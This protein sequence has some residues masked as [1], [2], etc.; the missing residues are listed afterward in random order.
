MKFLQLTSDMPNCHKLKETIWWNLPNLEFLSNGR[1]ALSH[2]VIDFVNKPAIMNPL[3]I[4]TNLID[5]DI[6][7]P[8]GLIICLPARTKDLVH[9]SNIL[10]F[11]STDSARPRN[12]MF[13]FHG[14]SI[15]NILFTSIVLAIE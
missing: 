12:V 4:S 8:D 6:Y 5:R 10:E 7:N 1:I 13:T 3:K 14:T 9:H 2:L 11:W 15:D